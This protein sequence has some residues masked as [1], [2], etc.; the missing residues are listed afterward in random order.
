MKTNKKI[1]F[2]TTAALT[3]LS[4][5]LL[6][7]GGQTVNAD[8]VNNNDQ[9]KNN[10]QTETTQNQD[11]TEKQL[12]QDVANAK[13]DVAQKQNDVEVATKNEADAKQ[14]VANAQTDLDNAKAQKP[15][16]PDQT[17]E[18]QA[19][20]NVA[21]AQKQVAEAKQNVVNAQNDQT[22]KQNAVNTAKQNL[23]DKQTQQQTAQ[24]NAESATN[25]ANKAKQAVDTKKQE[26]NKNRADEE[27]TNRIVVS[28]S[29]KDAVKKYNDDYVNTYAKD[30]VEALNNAG[31]NRK[32]FDDTMR[33]AS[34]DSWK[35]NHYVSNK[36]DE[37]VTVDLDNITN[38]QQDE[39]NKYAYG[40]LEDV[41]EQVGAPKL[42]LNTH[43][44]QMANDIAARYVKD[45][46][47][48][49][50]GQSHDYK[51]IN[52]IAKQYGYESTDEP[53]SQFYENMAGFDTQSKFIDDASDASQGGWYVLSRDVKHTV[54]MDLLKHGIF[55]DLSDMLFNDKEWYHAY[56]LLQ[57]ANYAPENGSNNH[58]GFSISMLPNKNH[59]TT[60]YITVSDSDALDDK[61]KALLDKTDVSAPT[62]SQVIAKAN[63]DSKLSKQDQIELD[64]L[65]RDYQ[66]KLNLAEKLQTA[67]DNAEQAVKDAQ[68]ALTNAE[69]ALKQSNANVTIA[70][71]KQ[72]QAE[73]ELANAKETLKQVTATDED[74]A[75]A[76]K[77]YQDKVT[78][79]ENALTD[80]QEKH[81][82]AIDALTNAK[83][84]LTDAQAKLK[85]AET[86]QAAYKQAQQAKAEQAKKEAEKA[87]A[88]AD[89][90]AK[91][92]AEK[93][94]Q[95][96]AEKA[97]AEAEKKAQDEAEKAKAEADAKAKADAEKKA[98]E[99]VDAKAKADAEKK[100]QA[101]ADARAKAELN[102]EPN[103]IGGDYTPSEPSTPSTETPV[104]KTTEKILMHAAYLYDNKG[105]K[106]DKLTV[107]S[108]VTVVVAENPVTINGIK[109]YKVAGKDE[110]INAGNIDGTLRVI[111]HNLYIY[112]NKGKATRNKGIK[113]LVKKTRIVRT[114]GAPIN[115]KGH[116]M[117]R[118]GKNR[119]IK[120]RNFEGTLRRLS[121]NSFVYDENGKA[122]RNKGIRRL[123]KK[124]RVVRT[125]NAP[126]KING[127]MM[128]RVD[129]GYVKVKNFK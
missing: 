67:A 24:T 118:I 116:M 79:K 87:K 64:K 62:A 66:T 23:T 63:A 121:H 123:L 71:N 89:A 80:A 82:Q 86:V 7:N 35:M 3:A 69:N 99:E 84:A 96:E 119:Y 72:K 125:F 112:N 117:Y 6:V 15:A 11:Q 41:R 105:I 129:S 74:Y 76:L 39:L 111:T 10:A 98:Q 100:A 65:Q 9:A 33:K 56:G 49:A 68:T 42:A 102:G 122:T 54:T 31:M 51:G 73:A 108:S 70:Q 115:I 101:E 58:F 59:V 93:K 107:K 120:A 103:F 29:Y 1:T 12:D 106:I 5:S 19:T 78:A 95:E 81:N 124:S 60:H 14:N 92:E 38:E 17:K 75:K 32:D 48:N 20:Q 34:A 50:D 113:R 18:T 127:H 104:E 16:E 88:E 26:L 44:H 55:Y 128:Y 37:S 53:D 30:P 2:L 36:K 90:K 46:R 28:Q 110:Y 97:K 52:D 22:A 43:V 57:M 47:A 126:V 21:N 45:G 85:K 4:A 91:A 13:T 40:L 83:K 61:G 114:Y 109:Y 94:A 8:T 77:S 25:D 27:N